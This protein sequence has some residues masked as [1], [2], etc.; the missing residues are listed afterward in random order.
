[1][2]VPPAPPARVDSA[3]DV[4]HGVEVSD[5]YRWLEDP[6]SPETRA[7]VEAQNHRTRT[8]LDAI[9]ARAE[10]RRRLEQ[11]LRVTVTTSPKLGGD[12]VFSLERGGDRDQA[13]L[14][15]RSASDR[16]APPRTLVDP[17]A[18]TG[19]ATVALDWFHPSPD[20]GLVAYGTSEAGDERSTLRVLDAGTGAPLA[21]FIPHTRAASV[22]WLPDGSAFAYTRY[23][24]P[25]A[26]GEDEAGYHRWVWWH[27]IGDDPATD[28]LVWGGDDL[29]D[30]TAWPNVSL[31]PDGRW[32]LVHVSLGWSRVDV[33]LLDRA[34]GERVAVVDGEEA[35]T[36]LQ[37]VGD[38][39]YGSTTLGAPRGRVVTAHVADPSA[40]RWKTLVAESEAV[41][42]G[43][44]VAGASLLVAST[45][46]AVAAL[47]RYHL[48]GP[49]EPDG[50]EVPLPG[51]GALA[52]LDADPEEER[53]FVSFA[54]F[55]RPPSLLRWEP[56]GLKPWSAVDGDGAV[57]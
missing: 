51:I 28:E 34:T 38:R 19:D 50:T 10:L 30:K 22:A 6:D 27:V 29:P 32:L 3:V 24:D 46:V 35:V 31:S 41:I 49:G 13:V 16:R 8:A 45:R 23:P 20:G 2:R 26:V 11:L 47:H 18:G 57:D 9:P 42:E 12:R 48:D 56:A 15:V 21:D 36:S 39:L 54:S 53:A 43:T 1:M 52:G 17:A 37:V 55:A 44:V 40:P 14:V 25:A 5:P 4:L 7:W 33:H